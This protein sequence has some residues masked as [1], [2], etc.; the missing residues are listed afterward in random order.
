MKKQYLMLTLLIPGP[1]S[2]GK[3]MDVF[4]QPFVEELKELWETEFRVR[5]GA[6]D[7]VFRLRAALLWTI[8]DFPARSYLSG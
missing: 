6:N 8:N 7:E 1:H 3:D 4:L 2:P 5:D